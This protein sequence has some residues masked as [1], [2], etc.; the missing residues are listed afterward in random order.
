MDNFNNKN[1]KKLTNCLYT[2]RENA[3][4]FNFSRFLYYYK[5]TERRHAD[6]ETLINKF[7]LIPQYIGLNCTQPAIDDFPKDFFTEEQRQAG[8]VVLHAVCSLYL[9]LAL[10]V[11]CDKYFVPAVEKIC[12]G[13]VLGFIIN[14]SNYFILDFVVNYLTRFS[15][16][17]VK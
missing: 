10:A 1:H 17:Y 2:K 12:T 7:H 16:K 8:A 13:N 5:C 11:V 14:N 4:R 3:Y 6:I 9:F 15:F